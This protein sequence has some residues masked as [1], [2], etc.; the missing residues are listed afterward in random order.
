MVKIGGRLRLHAA[1]L[2]T[3]ACLSVASKWEIDTYVYME[4]YAFGRHAFSSRDG[5]FGSD[6]ANVVFWR[7]VLI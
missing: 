5:P 7:A 6:G 2:C 1:V 4:P 3:L